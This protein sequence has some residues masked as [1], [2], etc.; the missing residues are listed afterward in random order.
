VEEG[1][2]PDDKVRFHYLKSNLF[3]I[4]HTDGAYGGLTPRLDIFVSF[5]SERPPIPQVMVNRM[6][7][8]GKLG[9]EIVEDRQTRDGI[10]REAEVG[11]TMTVDVAKALAGWLQEKITEA[12]RMRQSSKQN[13]NEE[14]TP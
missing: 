1:I 11:M 10:I 6:D 13:V 8:T 3:R 12:E 4:I 7:E 5:F 9:T 2:V 14:K